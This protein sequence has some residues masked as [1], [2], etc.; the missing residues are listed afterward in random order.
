MF[1]NK[2]NRKNDANDSKCLTYE[3]Y[4]R[5]CGEEAAYY[6]KAYKSGRKSKVLFEDLGGPW[7]KHFC[8]AFWN[9]D[10]AE[11]YV[12]GEGS[13]NIYW[14]KH[15]YD[16]WYKLNDVSDDIISSRY[17][18]VYLIWYFD[19]YRIAR[20]VR[21]GEGCISAGLEAARRDPEVQRYTGRFLYATW[22]LVSAC[23]RDSVAV[24]LSQKLQPFAGQHA[25][26]RDTGFFVGLPSKIRWGN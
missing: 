17:D 19:A 23:N 11:V 21:V 26:D 2:F 10:K 7:P 13:M 14:V 1:Y 15:G 20:T 3:T 22:A 25:S 5:Y 16:R 4:C 8:K 24:S 9:T 6:E 18:G 12:C